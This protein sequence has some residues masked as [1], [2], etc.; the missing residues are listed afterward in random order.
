MRNFIAKLACAALLG[1]LLTSG[2]NAAQVTCGNAALGIRVTVVDPGLAGGYCYAQNG[3]LQNADITALGLTLIAKEVAADGDVASA[4]LD[5]TIGGNQF[6]TWDIASSVWH[7]Y[8]RVFLGFH[9]GGGGNTSLDNPDSFIVE[10]AP[11]DVHGTW[12]LTGTNA[13]LNGLSNIYL[14]GKDPCRGDCRPPQ[15]APEPGSLALIALGLLGLAQARR[16]QGKRG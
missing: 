14:I 11:V 16:R 6:G 1:G 3:N 12:T 5:F 7:Q 8:G 10:L 13:Q 2:A 15:E 4:L 9:F